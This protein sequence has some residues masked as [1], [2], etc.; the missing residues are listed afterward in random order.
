MESEITMIRRYFVVWFLF[1]QRQSRQKYESLSVA[2][3]LLMGCPPAGSL[4]PAIIPVTGVEA[5]SS[6]CQALLHAQGV[7]EVYVTA[8]THV[9]L[10]TRLITFTCLPVS[11]YACL[12]SHLPIHLTCIRTCLAAFLIAALVTR[13]EPSLPWGN[14]RSIDG[15]RRL[16]RAKYWH[17]TLSLSIYAL[18]SSCNIN[19]QLRCKIYMKRES[20]YSFARNVGEETSY[21]CLSVISKSEA[22]VY[23][24]QGSAQGGKGRGM[25]RWLLCGIRA[26]H[27]EDE[28]REEEACHLRGGEII[29]PRKVTP[30][31]EDS[32]CLCVPRLKKKRYFC[33]VFHLRATRRSSVASFIIGIWYKSHRYFPDRRFFSSSLSV[34]WNKSL[35]TYFICFS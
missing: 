4:Q 33:P 23:H 10:R 7:F 26:C 25:P 5:C 1:E 30:S 29:Y 9:R 31:A 18:L 28:R 11:A 6:T 14:S 15:S 12:S 2:P 17:T 34:L 32:L 3:S 24:E 13:G 21:F 8:G 19:S 20:L 16:R 22:P 27:G 35:I